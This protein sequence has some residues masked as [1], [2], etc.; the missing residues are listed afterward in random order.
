M[1]H[2]VMPRPVRRRHPVIEQAEVY[3]GGQ[4]G[5]AP[6]QELIAGAARTTTANTESF[7]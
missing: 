6:L 2:A 7:T 4:V 5:L 1:P 3:A